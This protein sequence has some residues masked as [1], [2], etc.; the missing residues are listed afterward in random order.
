MWR[1]VEEWTK[2]VAGAGVETKVDSCC[3][4]KEANIL[5]SF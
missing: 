3:S 1:T 5:F 4:P 2:A